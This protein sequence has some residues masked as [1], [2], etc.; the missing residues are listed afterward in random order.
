MITFEV[1]GVLK[2]SKIL[3]E[4][5]PVE[6]RKELAKAVTAE[7]KAIQAAAKAAAPGVTG[8][9][10][11]D[12][13]IRRRGKGLSAFVGVFSKERGYIARFLTFGT[14]PHEIKP[15]NGNYL[16]IGG[17]LVRSI[18]HPGIKPHDF[19]LGPSLAR[20]E[21]F[22]QTMREAMIAALRRVQR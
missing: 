18:M 21:K 22:Q 13:R 12:V 7:A 4:T 3:N 14:K 5:L 15:K 19:L 6:V 20:R 8:Q 2:V 9:L 17:R 1:Q 11:R 16:N 10:R